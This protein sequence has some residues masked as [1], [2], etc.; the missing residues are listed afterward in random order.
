MHGHSSSARE[1]WPAF[2]EFNAFPRVFSSRRVHSH[3]QKNKSRTL[4]PI[5]QRRA[6]GFGMTISILSIPLGN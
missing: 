2:F 1:E 4:T 3:P 5:R 6:A